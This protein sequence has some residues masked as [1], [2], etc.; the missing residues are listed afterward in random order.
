MGVIALRKLQGRE[1]SAGPRRRV[2]GA[3]GS[4]ASLAVLLAGCGGG[5]AG[6][7]TAGADPILI[8]SIGPRTNA[9][10]LVFPEKT[11]GIEAGI[12]AINKAGGIKGRPLELVDCD[13]R[14]Q[15]NLELSCTREVLGKNVVAILDSTIGTDQSG[16]ELKMISVA[17]VPYFGSTG[18]TPTELTSPAVFPL[19]AG[20]PGF[21]YGAAKILKEKGATRYAVYAGNNTAALNFAVK[22]VVGAMQALGLGEPVSVVFGDPGADPTLA[23]SAAKVTSDGVDGII[24]LPESGALMVKA[25]RAT[26]YKG[27]LSGLS[28]QFDPILATLGAAADGIFLV[29]QTAFASDPTNPAVA[30]FISDMK[31]YQPNGTI[32]QNSLSS[33]A[34]L[35]LFARIAKDIPGPTVDAASFKAAVENVSTPI[36]TGLVGEWAIKGRKPIVPTAPRILNPS[37][38]FGVVKNGKIVS[39]VDGFVNPFVP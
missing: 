12:E 36:D 8:A 24:M 39:A 32:N 18:V 27:L 5:S 33:Y 13:T 23:A 10:S 20:A 38:A 1:G 34:A 9:T 2:V 35:Q 4:V 15:A 6:D 7:A 21:F 19:A 22:N 28:T 26:G 14:G 37:M 3:L 11:Q 17:G 25:L 16:A 31:T 29:S 30:Q